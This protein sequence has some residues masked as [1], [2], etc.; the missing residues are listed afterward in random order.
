MPFAGERIGHLESDPRLGGFEAVVKII[1]VDLQ[2]LALFDAGEGLLGIAGEIRHHPHHEGKLDLLLRTV[3]LHVVFDLDAWGTIPRYEFLSAV[4]HDIHLHQ[5]CRNRQI[6]D[7]H[8][9]AVYFCGPH[10]VSTWSTA[11]DATSR[12][13]SKKFAETNRLHLLSKSGMGL[14]GSLRS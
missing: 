3:E 5:I 13:M 7:D 8:R 1:H 14:D 6:S 9:I 2:E 11:F 4:A 10:N 12:T